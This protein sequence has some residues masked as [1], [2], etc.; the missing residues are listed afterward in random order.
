MKTIFRVAVLLIFGCLLMPLASAQVGMPYPSFRDLTPQE[1][2]HYNERPAEILPDAKTAFEKGNYDR[3]IMLCSM[4]WAY[5]GDETNKL[6]DRTQL[7]AKAKKCYDLSREMNDLV[8]QRKLTAAK[9]KARAI[10]DINAQDP[11]A[12]EVLNRTIRVT[13]VTVTPDTSS[14]KEAETLQ[15]SAHVKPEDASN[16]AVLWISGDNSVATVNQNGMVKALKAGRVV[17]TVITK[18]GDFMGTSKIT[19]SAVPK[20]E[21]KVEPKQEQKVEQIVE[22]KVE[23]K[24]VPKPEPVKVTGITVSQDSLSLEVGKLRLLTAKVHPDDAADKTFVWYSSDTSVARVFTNGY[25]SAVG[26]GTTAITAMTVDGNK[27]D[28]CIVVVYVAPEPINVAKVEKK[29]RPAPKPRKP[30]IMVA[31]TV[32]IVPG[33]SYGLMA[34]YVGK[35]GGY[36][37]FRSNF[38]STGSTYD[39]T[40][41]GR[42]G[43]DYIWT[44]G[45]TKVSLMSATAGVLI[46]VGRSVIPYVGAGY[47]KRE[48][49]WEDVDGAWARVTDASVSGIGLEAGL[50]LRFGLFGIHA[51]V[52]TAGFKNLGVDAGIALFF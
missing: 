19:V 48:L 15:L 8:S 9:Q 4:H 28:S 44:T 17:I 23:L 25:V 29:A 11:A 31:P 47:A 36:A 32:G 33:L 7:E 40:S 10:L 2:L 34:G 30:C 21:P 38:V 24:P 13:G 16:Q 1:R 3:A 42:S 50:M 35:L 51:G 39:C 46:P 20:P 26:P 52:N 6:S 22:Q 45:S 37:K 14:I 27:K 43:S 41:D 5:Y 12:R 49:A 18:D